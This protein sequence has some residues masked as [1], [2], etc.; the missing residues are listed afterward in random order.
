MKRVKSNY[1]VL[2]VLKNAK[3]KLRKAII[4]NC[5]PD[6]INCI[7]ECALNVLRGT[8]K[9]S[10]CMK[11]K[12]RKHRGQLRKVTDKSVPLTSKRRLVVQK[13]GFLV[14]LLSAVLPLISTLLFRQ[15]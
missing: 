15:K 12:L 6:L 1:N 11:R 4:S 2:H 9:L 3:P 5:T 7:S 10:T 14:P 8:I 13:G